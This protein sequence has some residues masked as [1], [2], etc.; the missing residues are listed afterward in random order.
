VKNE[1]KM[2]SQMVNITDT[3]GRENAFRLDRHGFEYHTHP[4][5]TSCVEDRYA[6][7]AALRAEY[8]PECE[9]VIQ[10]V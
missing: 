2:V 6:D 3:T 8:F 9:R 4:S 5:T 1:R 7:E 10:E